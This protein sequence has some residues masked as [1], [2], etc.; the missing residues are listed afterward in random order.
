[1]KEKYLSHKTIPL[2]V[3]VAA[4]VCQLLEEMGGISFQ[5][6]NLSTCLKV[7]RQMLKD[8]TLI[9]LGLSGALIPAGLRNVFVYLIQNRLID[10]LVS[11]GANLFHDC[12]ESVGR[13][14]YLGDHNVNDLELKKCSIDRIYDT[15]AS[16]LEFEETDK[17]IAKFASSLDCSYPYSTREFFYLLGKKIVKGNYTEGILTSAYKAKVPIYCPA[18]GDSSVGIAI[19]THT[20]KNKSK[21]LFDVI[22]D[23]EETAGLI[24]KA[25]STGVIY[26]G[27]GTPKNFIQQTE[28]TAF[29]LKNECQPGHKYAIQITADAPHWGGLSGCT[30]SEAQSWGK[31]HK[32]AKMVT[33]Y[34]DVT[35]ALP[36]LVTGLAQSLKKKPIKR[37]VPQFQ[38]DQKELF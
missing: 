16:E 26:L 10:C 20:Y 8:K 7:W 24:T 19:A 35:L 9:F 2:K 23:V 15:F 17:F 22:K 4:D 32:E 18:V 27:G 34:S 33:V 38:I 1:M 3:D 6:R 37:K 5:G 11:T 14:H 29:L 21:F 31:I 30:F 25:Q 12:H 28:I 36:I 13:F